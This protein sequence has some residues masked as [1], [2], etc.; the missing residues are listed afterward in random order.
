MSVQAFLAAEALPDQVKT[1]C[2]IAAHG[3][4]TSQCVAAQV[5]LAPRGGLI[6]NVLDS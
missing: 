2:V 3:C 1:Q 6:V 5:A 4:P